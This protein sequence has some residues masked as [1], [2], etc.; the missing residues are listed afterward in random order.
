M[1]ARVQ[2]VVDLVLALLEHGWLESTGWNSSASVFLVEVVVMVVVVVV[3]V[4]L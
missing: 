2:C 3:M 1:Y 4:V